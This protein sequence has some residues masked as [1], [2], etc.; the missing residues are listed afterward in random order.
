MTLDKS[1]EVLEELARK[2]SH[3]Y[4]DEDLQAVKLGIEAL[5]Y[6]EG[7]RQH[8]GDYGSLVLPGET[9]EGEHSS[10]TDEEREIVDREYKAG[11]EQLRQ[12][13]AEGKLSGGEHGN[14]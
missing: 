7:I 13:Y 8:D 11:C 5:R 12:W 4:D 10:L 2:W 6:V 3:D 9:A 14:P 1:I